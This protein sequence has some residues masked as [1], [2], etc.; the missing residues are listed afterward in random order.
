V[1]DERPRDFR[2]VRHALVLALA[3]IGTTAM[4]SAAQV[5]P[6]PLVAP[7]PPPAT[8]PP[9][10]PALEIPPGYTIGADDVLNVMFWRDKEMTADV[11]VRPDGRI[12]LPLVN[13]VIAAGLTPEQL[14]D[15]V[16]TEASKFVEEPSV[17][18]VVKQINSRR[19]FI[20]GMVGKPGAYPMTRAITVLQLISLAGGLDEFANA[21]KVVIM[22]NEGGRQVAM[23]F[24]YADVRQGK[25]LEQN[26]ELQAGDTVVVP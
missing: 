16:R 18:V 2:A 8:P 6:P 10:T 22:R 4:E 13:D 20:T 25:N 7:V 3:L 21:K 11:V 23:K 17:T 1:M 19:V 12:T 26:I 15:R 24:N 9:A 5:Q 14:R